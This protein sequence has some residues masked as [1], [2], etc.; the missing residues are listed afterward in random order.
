MARII[1]KK[2]N[3]IFVLFFLLVSW[4]FIGLLAKS[5]NHSSNI[6]VVKDVQAA[7]CPCAPAC[8]G[9]EGSS[10]AEAEAEAECCEAE[11]AS[12]GGCDSCG[13]GEGGGE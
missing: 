12:G 3:S 11:C 1:R 8:L 2:V 13:E 4:V 9:S 5:I 7:C 6:S 10:P